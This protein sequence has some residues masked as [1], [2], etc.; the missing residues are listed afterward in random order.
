MP[1]PLIG[2]IENAAKKALV[3]M[4]S[5]AEDKIKTYIDAELSSMESRVNESIDAKI[6][7]EFAKLKGVQ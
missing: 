4:L 1:S 7:A 3:D 2:R 5:G 6:T